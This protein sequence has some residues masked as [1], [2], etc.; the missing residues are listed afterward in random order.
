MTALLLAALLVFGMTSAAANAEALYGERWAQARGQAWGNEPAYPRPRYGG[1]EAPRSLDAREAQSPD[2]YGDGTRTYERGYDD[3]YRDPHD[4][5][6]YPAETWSRTAAPEEWGGSPALPND[7]RALYPPADAG[8]GRSELP[9]SQP[10]Y[11]FRGDPPPGSDRRS[12]QE[13]ADG[14][15]FRPLTG[16][17]AE[18]RAQTPGWRPLEQDRLERSG[19]RSSPSGQPS[20]TGWGGAPGLMDALTPPP[21]TFGFEPTPWP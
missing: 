16:Q 2:A 5:G 20:G 17:E 9:G 18:R 3:V 14:Y 21:R 1:Y 7:R 12:T 4:P 19:S 8:L 11:R 15:R 6:G 10:E 13:G